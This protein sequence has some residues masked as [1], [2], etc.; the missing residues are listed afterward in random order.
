MVFASTAT[1]FL[2]VDRFG[3]GYVTIDQVRQHYAD[4]GKFNG[5]A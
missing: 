2:I 3:T 5:Y 1:T 4:P